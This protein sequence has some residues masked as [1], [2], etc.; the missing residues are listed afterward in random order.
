MNTKP[1]E[2]LSKE[3][4]WDELAIRFPAA[5]K[6]FFIWLEQWK[7]KVKWK[8]MFFVTKFYDVPIEMQYG[9]ILQFIVEH[10]LT[11]MVMLSFEKDQSKAIQTQQLMKKLI[12]LFEKLEK[13]KNG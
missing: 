10:N 7:A 6:I 3:N 9:I 4:F 11:D 5:S 12:F 13:S 2:K 1:F 8:T